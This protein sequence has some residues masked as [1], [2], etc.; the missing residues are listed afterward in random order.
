MKKSL[1]GCM[2]LTL[3]L[4]FTVFT[5]SAYAVE[6]FLDMPD[7]WSTAALEK[8]VFNGLLK[9]T[10][11]KIL[12]RE[13]LSRAQMA[14]VVERAFGAVEKASLDKFVDVS[15]SD[16]FYDSMAKAVFM[17]AFA[18]GG[19]ELR[20]ND[21]ITREEAFVVLARSIKLSGAS[22]DILDK[23]YDKESIS[24]W[25]LDGVASMVEAGYI[26]G[27]EG[28]INPKKY[29][30]R[31]EFAQVMDNMLKNYI[32]ASGNYTEDL[33]GNVIIRVSDV[34]LSNIKIDG[35]LIIADGVGDG[36]ITLDGITVTGRIV[37][38]GGG[39]NSIRITGKS[40]LKNIIIARVDGKVR[41][42][43]EDGI[44]VGDIIADGSDDVIIEGYFDEV[45]VIAPDI[46]VTAIN[47]NISSATI[48]GENSTIIV[49]E[50]STTNKIVLSSSNSSAEIA[51]T[52]RNIQTT[53]DAVN[54]SIDTVTGSKVSKID[55]NG[56]GTSVTG[57]GSV[58]SVDAN[59]DNVE[60]TTPNTNVTAGSGT[61]GV[62]AGGVELRSG[63]SAN[64][65]N[66]GTG[67]QSASYSKKQLTISDPVLTLSKV[68]DGTNAASVTAGILSGVKSGDVIDVT[69]TAYYD[70]ADAGTGKTIT[71]EYEIS[72]DNVNDYKKPANYVVNTGEI[73]KKQMFVA[74]SVLTKEKTYNGNNLTSVSVGDIS[75]IVDSDSVTVNAEAVYDTKNAGTNKTITVEYI[76]SGT[77]AGNYMKPDGYTVADGEI[78]AR[79]LTITNLELSSAKEYDG[80]INAEVNINNEILTG[81]VDGDVVT[82][83]ASASYDNKNAGTEKTITVEYS[84][85]GIDAGNYVKP[86]DYIINSGVIS[87]KQLSIT[88]PAL[89]LTKEYDGNS[90]ADAVK[91]TLSGV[92]DGDTVNVNVSAYYDNKNVGLNKKI[93]VEYAMSGADKD[94]YIALPDYVAYDGEITAKQL[95]ITE[96]SLTLTKEYD[97]NTEANMVLGTMSGKI[98][99]DDLTLNYDAEYDTKDVGTNKDI[100]VSYSISG[101]DAGNYTAPSEYTVHNGEIRK[102]QLTISGLSVDLTK[103]YDKSRT[104]SVNDF[105]VNGAAVGETVTLGVEANYDSDNA[106]TDKLITVEYTISLEDSLNYIKPVNDAFTNGEITAKQLIISAPVLT[107]SKEYDG[108]TAANVTK[109]S[110]SGV[111]DGDMVTVDASAVYENKNAGSGKMIT[112]E[113]TIDGTDKANYAAPSDYII[114]DGV[115]TAK[116]LTIT[117]PIL[118]LSKEY[119]GTISADVIPG[120]LSGLISGDVVNVEAAASYDDPS[121]EINKTITVV[122]TLIGDDAGN[123]IKPGDFTVTNGSIVNGEQSAP[124]GL[125][126][127]SPTSSLND[128]GKITGTTIEM[129]YKLSTGS[130]WIN[131]GGTEITGLVPG[132]YN[133][134][135][136]A[137]TGYNASPTVNVTV[138][139][140][141]A[142]LTSKSITKFDYSTTSPTSPQVVSNQINS[143][144]FSVNRVRFDI[145]DGQGNRI[146][147]DLWWNITSDQ[148]FTSAQL[149]GSAIESTIQDWFYKY[150]GGADGI[151]NRTLYAMGLGDKVTIGAFGSGS[152]A[153][154]H[155]YQPGTNTSYTSA[156]F[157]ENAAV[158]LDGVSRSATF[159]IGDGTNSAT[160][161]LNRYYSSINS[162]V[163]HIN[164]QISGTEVSATVVA[165]GTDKF[166]IE[167]NN[168]TISGTDKEFFFSTFITE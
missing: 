159:T 3:L 127:I 119:D 79:Q 155:L 147:V 164:S 22:E 108:S 109:G 87:A 83:D 105:T 117:D 76:I 16:W 103:E 77:D 59:A 97:G 104:A 98:D 94:N 56:E 132:T 51:G 141:I 38:R 35:D 72:G 21:Y 81:V 162:M 49:A 78:T 93:T 163:T 48:S 32:S 37:I 61:T 142:S 12:P 42:Y 131:V 106:G 43:T 116:A 39:V 60:V 19:N 95:T 101:A 28:N 149:V 122:Y 138:D 120:I 118:T 165:E 114:Y 18:G 86:A 33:T 144:D 161:T 92:V 67:I 52:V 96:P 121:V 107:L 152:S 158:G 150:K 30:T 146:P 5:A 99:E 66:S 1:L 130:E 133:V 151:M 135:L 11:G 41:V 89:T 75:G 57:K 70:T 91:G 156:L 14:A 47:A 112:V 145:V 74:N 123:Y 113:Y 73:T 64:V 136:K 10:D 69:A 23:F 71:V 84:I 137:K 20:P 55:I 68:Y 82:I 80:N 102:K 88:L 129:E 34:E 58:S 134:R 26:S 17:K 63:Q 4:S 115:I 85:S 40:N 90:T 9:G 8:S 160:I 128:D 7:D 110:L 27:S 157:T 46:V 25:A 29:I 45:L 24:D 62:M 111:I 31:A 140:Y 126:G 53:S 153:S 44:E 54:A 13:N 143:S 139:E 15:K 168:I 148:G 100:T 6:T 2:L 154:I 166:I 50:N 65:N 36:D 167:G 124:S 125:T